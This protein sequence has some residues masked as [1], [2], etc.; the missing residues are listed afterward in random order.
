MKK[1]KP[2]WVRP[3]F[4]KTTFSA[5]TSLQAL[6]LL[7]HFAHPQPDA[8][9]LQGWI[10]SDVFAA[11]AVACDE[12]LNDCNRRNRSHLQAPSRRRLRRKSCADLSVTTIKSSDVSTTGNG[13]QLA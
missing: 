4:Q 5:L 11:G 12:S 13:L 6:Q 3:F 10:L 8:L 2:V 7:L 1:G 9:F